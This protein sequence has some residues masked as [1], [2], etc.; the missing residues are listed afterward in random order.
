MNFGLIVRHALN[1]AE[2]PFDSEHLDLARQYANDNIEKLWYKVKADFRMS[3]DTITTVAGSDEYV[4]NKYVDEIVRGTLR[5][6][7][8]YPRILRYKKNTEFFRMSKDSN[9]SEGNPKMWTY[10]E[11]SGV[12]RQ[13]T[14]GTQ[15]KVSSSLANTTGTVA[16]VTSSKFINGSS[17]SLNDVGLRF[18]VDGDTETYKIGKFHSTT[19]LELMTKYRGASNGTATY[20]IG[21]V[22]IH[23]NISGFVGGQMDS[24]DVELNGSDVKT[25][26]KTFTSLSS[27]SKSDLTGGKITAT[28][29]AGSLNLAILAPGEYEVERQTIVLWLIPDSAET[30]HYRFY[31]KHPVL[32]LD[33]DRPLLPNKHHQLITQLTE[34]DLREFA[35]TQTPMGLSAKIND[36]IKKLEDDAEDSSL[37]NNIP[38]REGIDDLGD[39]FNNAVD[40][41]F[42]G[43]P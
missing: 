31:M 2:L 29:S 38:S 42:L 10:G 24:E 30:L 5:E 14:A 23:V 17:F 6:I 34:S 25:T 21:D 28:N 20:A 35:G 13:P 22:G 27:V 32:R 43:M 15:V 1:R 7:D 11:L 39:M 37:E 33:T 41:D 4:L 8:S 9:A 3:S 26:A 36:G 40:S 16:V 19:K 12:D 18:K